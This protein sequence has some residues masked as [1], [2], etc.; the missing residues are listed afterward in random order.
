MR[1]GMTIAQRTE[2]GLQAHPLLFF[3]YS[4][5]FLKKRK[6][7]IRYS[8]QSNERVTA[9]FQDLKRDS[10]VFSSI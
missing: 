10:R 7:R 6:S 4:A 8:T 1:I 2:S 5:L 9:F 3:R